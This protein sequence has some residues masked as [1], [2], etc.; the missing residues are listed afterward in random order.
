MLD[1]RGAGR[2]EQRSYWLSRYHS[3][4]LHRHRNATC[5]YIFMFSIAVLLDNQKGG[6]F[7]RLAELTLQI[8]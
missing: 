5:V 2:G 6:Y 1:S 8:M 4:A 7:P 3:P